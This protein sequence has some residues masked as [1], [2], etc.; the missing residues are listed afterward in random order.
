MTRCILSQPAN[1]Q[2]IEYGFKVLMSTSQE[3]VYSYPEEYNPHTFFSVLVSF[4]PGLY[5]V[6]IVTITPHGNI[7]NPVFTLDIY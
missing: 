5:F 2:V 1:N 6:R 3:G 4:P 7:Y